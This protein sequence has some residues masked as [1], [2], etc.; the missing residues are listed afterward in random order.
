LE[1]QH[2]TKYWTGAPYY[3]FGCSAHSYDGLFRR[4]ANERDV[5]RYLEMTEQSWRAIVSETQ[6]TDAE[7]KAEAVFLGL[8]MM[9]GMS[10]QDYEQEFGSDL[11]TEH[12]DDLARF[13][14]AGLIECSGDLLKADSRGRVAIKRS[15][16]RVCLIWSAAARRPLW[17]AAA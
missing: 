8:R 5:V 7:V 14:E 6:L 10:F 12:Q 9:Q 15:F 4:W 13:R 3:G 2:N 11:R 17:S 1:S 16:L